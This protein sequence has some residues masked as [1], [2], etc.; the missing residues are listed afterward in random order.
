MDFAIVLKELMEENHMTQ[1]SLAK[2]IGYSQRAVSKWI[3][4]QSEPSATA[5]YKCAKYF[6]VSADYLLGL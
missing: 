3:R 6:N 5:I 4:G 1:E 2:A